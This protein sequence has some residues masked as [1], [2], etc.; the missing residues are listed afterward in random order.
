MV[1]PAAPGNSAALP[2]GGEMQLGILP[3]P[4]SDALGPAQRNKP[5]GTHC[6]STLPLGAPLPALPVNACHVSVEGCPGDVEMA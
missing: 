5:L 4:L 6:P 1:A 3:P 2:E